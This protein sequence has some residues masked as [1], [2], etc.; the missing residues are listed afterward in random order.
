MRASWTDMRS[1]S[2]PL[3]MLSKFG[4]RFASH[5]RFWRA[6][7]SARRRRCLPLRAR[8]WD[9]NVRARRR[10]RSANDSAGKEHGTS[11]HLHGHKNYSAI[12]WG[13]SPSIWSGNLAAATST[14]GSPLKPVGRV[15]DSPL[16]GAGLYAD[17][18]SG[19]VSATGHGERIIPLAW[20]KAIA[21]LMKNGLDGRD[22]ASVAITML[23]RVQ[24]RAGVIVVDPLGR[25]GVAYNTPAMAY[26]YLDLE[27]NEIQATRRPD[28]A[29]KAPPSSHPGRHRLR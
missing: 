1:Q 17:N 3:P 19:A 27:S 4:T 8:Q 20:S 7:C 5:E 23:D 12:Q 25:V 10:L 15:G 28:A 18:H 14:G 26:A 21:D 22:A 2:A 11:I 29:A 16:I 13:Q 24:A 6:A 9:R